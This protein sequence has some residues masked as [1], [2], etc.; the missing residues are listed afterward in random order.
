MAFGPFFYQT[1]LESGDRRLPLLTAGKPL[2]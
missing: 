2:I 1:N